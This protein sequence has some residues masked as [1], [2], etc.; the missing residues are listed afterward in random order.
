MTRILCVWSPSW[1]IANWRRR[2]PSASSDKPF[3]LIAIERGVRRLSAVDGAAAALGLFVGQKATDA[4]ALVPDLAAADADPRPIRPRWRR[5]AT[6]ARASRPPLRSTRP[7][8]CSSI[9]PAS[10]ICGAA[11]R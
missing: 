7:T 2:N 5:F 10:T 6:G 8:A 11:R 9:S 4:V 3:A 1:A